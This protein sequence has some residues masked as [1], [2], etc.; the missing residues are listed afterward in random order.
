LTLRTIPI[1]TLLQRFNFSI[2]NAASVGM[3]CS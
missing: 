3:T 1:E 2:H